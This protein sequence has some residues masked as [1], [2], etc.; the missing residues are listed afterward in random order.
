MLKTNCIVKPVCLLF[1]TFSLFFSLPAQDAKIEIKGSVVD[2]N[3]NSPL[4]SASIKIKDKNLGSITNKLGQFYIIS[5]RLPVVLE[6]SYV[7]YETQEYTVKFEPLQPITIQMVPKTE[8]LKGV[9]ITTEKID[10]VYRDKHYSVLDYELRSEG[11]VLLIYRYTLNRSE[12]VFKDYDGNRISA[13]N[14]LPGKPLRLFKD[15]LGEL[16]LFTKN[17]SYQLHFGEK[18]LKL[19]PAVDL[20]EFVQTMQYCEFLHNGK[21]YYHEQG[22]LDLIN[23]YYAIDTV[24]LERQNF[25]T[26]LDQEKIDF[27]MC[28]PENLSLHNAGFGPSLSDLQGLASDG[29]ILEEIRNMEVELRFNQMVYFP[30]IYAPMFKLGDSIIIFNHFNSTIEFFNK[31]DTLIESVAITY[32]LNPNKD[33]QNLI[34]S[35]ARIDKW[36]EEIFVD[37]STKKAYTSFINLNGIKTIKEIDFQ[38]GQLIRSIKIPF[39]YVEKVQFYNG[40]MYYIYKGWGENQKKKLFRQQLY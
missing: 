11:I 10:T 23:N 16:H 15:C 25:H 28:N 17:K 8:L 3:S 12:I 20:N 35:I 7:G 33:F 22:Y 26:V 38:S 32:H 31:G 6:I 14:T 4:V 1:C 21:L 37:Q 36:Q 2:I 34:S 19:Y 40:F 30:A 18:K 5:N 29:D 9:V 39:P 27:L 13:I 24:N